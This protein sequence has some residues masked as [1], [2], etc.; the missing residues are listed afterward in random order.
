M[1]PN[2]EIFIL[3]HKKFDEQYD[4]NLYKPLLNGACLLDEDYGYIRDDS[5]DNISKLNKYFAE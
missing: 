2:I 3:T 1:H 5:G 4:L